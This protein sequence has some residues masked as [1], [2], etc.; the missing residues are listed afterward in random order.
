MSITNSSMLV[1]LHISVWG[2]QKL[3]KSVTDK[4]IE[5]SGAIRGA[6][7][8]RKNL[9]AGTE[10]RKKISDLAAGIR[11]YHMN[12]TMPWADR[13]SR[14]L[15][16]SLFFDYK[17]EMNRK[18]TQF[19]NLVEEFLNEYELNKQTA[20]ENL[21]SLFNEADYPTINE[22]RSK[23]GF[24]LVFSPVPES[25]D[26]RVDM[27]DNE[28]NVLKA[29][30]EKSFEGRLAEA[31]KAPW[32]RLHTVLTHLSTRLQEPELAE[33]EPTKRKLYHESMIENAYE[34]TELLRSFN[35]T[36]DPKL[37]EARQDLVHAIEG[38]DILDIRESEDTRAKVKERVD[39]AL[40][41]FW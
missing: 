6:G 17:D 16:T 25:G 32:E 9:M 41:R 28:L 7:H 2:G 12:Y 11:N 3:D 23:F 5:E 35:L 34:L 39:A 30:Y 31:M 36:E 21:G 8:F 37:E 22:L 26:F 27:T 33:G 1:D 14:L 40:E 29:Q 15:P 20:K 19:N 4:T 18:E 10:K 13:G 24:N 38:V